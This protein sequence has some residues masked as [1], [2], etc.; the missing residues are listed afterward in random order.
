MS[1]SAVFIS[2]Q[3]SCGSVSGVSH[4]EYG[5]VYWD[6][7]FLAVYFF[8]NKPIYFIENTKQWIVYIF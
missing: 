4:E 8:S 3:I 7:L 2:K 6:I 5:A 1:T